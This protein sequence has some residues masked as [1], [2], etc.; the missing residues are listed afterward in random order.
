MSSNYENLQANVLRILEPAKLGDRTSKIWDLSLFGLV[1][2]NLIAVA[3]ESVPTLQNNYGSWF[4]NFEIFSVIIFTVEYVSRVWSAPAKR[5]HENGETG[6]KARMRYIFSFY[7]IIDLVA[8]LPFYIQA[9]FPGLDLRVLRALRLLRILK[10]NH[11]NS[12]LDDLFGAILEEKKS[13]LT[14]LYIFSVA[15]VLSSS[16]IYYAEHKVQPE[17]FRSIPDAMY[18]SIITLTTV[19]YGDV[20]PITVFGKSIAAITAIFGVV[21]VALLTGI[22]ANSFNAQMDRRKVIFEDQVRNALLD[23]VLDSD[24]EASLDD[25]RKKFGMSKLQ[26]DALINHVK[27]TREN[28]EL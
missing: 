2:L 14:T 25:L 11:Y 15:F 7:G 5:D 24:E 17:A 22:V 4:Y 19:G 18:W 1:L 12:A 27:K 20:S 10:L 13:F 8:I 21:V 23:G 16:L 3:L 9:F 26:A 28:P 6:L